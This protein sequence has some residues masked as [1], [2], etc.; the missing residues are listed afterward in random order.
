MQHTNYS[1]KDHLTT[2]KT[3]LAKLTKIKI[4]N[5]VVKTKYQNFLNHSILSN[6]YPIINLKM[7]SKKL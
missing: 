1:I 4:L 7:S 2:N 3:I 6:C 5:I